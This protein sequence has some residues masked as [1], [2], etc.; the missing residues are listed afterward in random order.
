[1]KLLKNHFQTLSNHLLENFHKYIGTDEL[2]PVMNHQKYI[3]DFDPEAEPVSESVIKFMDL[4]NE[5][6]NFPELAESYDHPALFFEYNA[7]SI[8]DLGK[9]SQQV[10][11]MVSL[12]FCD[13]SYLDSGSLSD[14][15]NEAL[16]YLDKL[17]IIHEL[18][19]GY[20]DPAV[21]VL[22]RAGIAKVGV[23]TNVL[24]YRLD[25][26]CTMIDDSGL[27][28]NK[29]TESQEANSELEF[30]PKPAPP[31]KPNW[32]NPGI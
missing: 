6:P 27:L 13:V 8:N 7:T 30:V 26:Q 21:G 4:W 17:G 14:A 28:A 32:F 20:A 25:F 15:Q 12:Y 19:H 18:L 11:L 31:T 9:L 3:E 5:Q 16:S 23:Q 1:M 29:Q 10:P 2:V 24:V 22:R